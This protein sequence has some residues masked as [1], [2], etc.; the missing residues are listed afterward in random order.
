MAGFTEVAGAGQDTFWTWREAMYRFLARLLPDDVEAI[1]AMAFADMLEG[2]FTRV[3]EFHYLHHAADGAPYAN[4]AEMAERV[5]AAAAT[6]GIGVTLLPVFY[7]HGGFGPA[8]PG[9]R[10]A[11]F[12]NDLDGFARIVAA[13]RAAAAGSDASVGVA[14]HSLRAATLEEVEAVA[15]LAAG[16]PVHIHVAEQAKEVEDCLAWS[17]ARPVALLLDNVE[18]DASWCLVHATHMDSSETERLAKTGAVVGLCPITEANLGDGLFPARDFLS[19][20]GRFGIGS[21]SNVRI[22]AAE[23]LRTLEYGQRLARHARNVLAAAGGS[24]GRRLFDVALAGGAQAL[25]QGE[26][27][28][29]AGRPADIVSLATIEAAEAGARGDAILDSWIFVGAPI[30]G[31]WRAGRKVVAQGRHVQ[32]DAIAARYRRTLTRLMQE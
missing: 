14:A 28:F 27:G 13:C 5:L 29:A 7:A 9:P 30:D 22:N 24:T 26:P 32:K 12:L 20:G 11:R 25:G 18:I 17:G 21:D 6:A 2:G 10:Q 19:A 1:A 23:E 8:L 31:V 16:A 15:A 4:A 3:G